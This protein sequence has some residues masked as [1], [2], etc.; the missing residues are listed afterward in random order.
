MAISKLLVANNIIRSPLYFSLSVSHT[1]REKNIAAGY[2][3]F[4]QPESV[5]AVARRMASGDHGI[6]TRRITLPEGLTSKEMSMI[7]AKELPQFDPMQ[8]QNETHDKE[9]YLFPDTY[10]FFT[11]ATSG[12]VRTA[13]EDNFFKKTDALH[14]DALQGDKNWNDILTMASIIE[15]EA[16]TKEDRYIVSGILWNR[17]KNNMRLQVDAPFAYILGKGSLQLTLDD[18]KSDSPYNTYRSFGLP[19]TPINN[20][21]LEA[22]D[23]ALHPATTTYMFYLS[24]KNGTMHY[25]KTFSEHKQ[26]KAKYLR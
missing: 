21:G 14:Q 19:P 2:Y 20:P 4:K 18:L 25:A 8:F 7:I 26:N 1:G 13:L 17:I 23:A 6:E 12:A 11:V 3:L 24:D 22:I 15:G 10:F 9:G 16:V 5:F